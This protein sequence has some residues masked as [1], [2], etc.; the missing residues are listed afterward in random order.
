MK[1][2]VA[3][4]FEQLTQE[5]VNVSTHDWIIECKTRADGTLWEPYYIERVWDVNESID[6]REQHGQFSYYAVRCRRLA[7][8]K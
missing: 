7:Y 8:G 4:Y 2:R 3:L 6:Y 1:V 5:D